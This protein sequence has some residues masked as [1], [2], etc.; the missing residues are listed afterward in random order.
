MP[1]QI[2]SKIG[3]DPKFEHFLIR[4]AAPLREA[5]NGGAQPFHSAWQSIS[6]HFMAR[7][8]L[9]AAMHSLWL[10][11]FNLNSF[12]HSRE[13]ILL[14]ATFILSTVAAEYT[15]LFSCC[16]QTVTNIG[17]FQMLTCKDFGTQ[18]TMMIN[19]WS[20]NKDHLNSG[21]NSSLF[22]KTLLHSCKACFCPVSSL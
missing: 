9:H 11:Y 1:L 18:G 5:L 8:S 19:W 14:S 20:S 2:L 13:K 3:A 21:Y 7:I 17:C 22:F 4:H 16:F 10:W 12:C 15:R 6:L